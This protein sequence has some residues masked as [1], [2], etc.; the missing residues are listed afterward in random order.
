MVYR[1]SWL[2]GIM[3][4]WLLRRGSSDHPGRDMCL[5]AGCSMLRGLELLYLRCWVLLGGL[6][7]C[8]CSDLQ[9]SCLLFNVWHLV[10]A[11]RSLDVRCDSKY[12]SRFFYILS[13][14]CHLKFFLYLWI[15][16]EEILRLGQYSSINSILS[17]G[18][19]APD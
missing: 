13:L 15:I 12:A 3:W 1:N 5:G 19:G 6:V 7:P 4:V 18:D 14:D 2:S 10:Y 8:S 11:V 17:K 16:V 9:S